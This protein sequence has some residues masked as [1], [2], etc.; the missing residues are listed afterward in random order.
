MPPTHTEEGTRTGYGLAALAVGV[1]IALVVLGFMLFGDFHPDGRHVE[2]HD[3]F[4]GF[5]FF[6]GLGI[7]WPDRAERV[8]RGTARIATAWRRKNGTTEETKIP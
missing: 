7:A 3:L 2:G 8:A 6:A 1:T 4:Y 5:A